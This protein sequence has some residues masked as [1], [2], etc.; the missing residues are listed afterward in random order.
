MKQTAIIHGLGEIPPAWAGDLVDLEASTDGQ[1]RVG[2][3]GVRR[4]VT[5]L[6]RRVELVAFENKTLAVVRST[7]MG[8][9]IYPLEPARFDP[10]ATAVLIDLDGTSVHSESFWMWIIER[11]IARLMGD[12]SFQLSTDD[13]PH[14]SGHSVSEHLQY[15]IN[16]YVPG[17]SIETAR[18]H[19]YEITE[20]EMAEIVAGRGKADAFTPAPGLKAF[21]LGLKAAG[22]KIG[23]VTS[24]L[25]NK[26]W[27]E[28]ISAFRQLDLG[29][30]LKFYD[31]II[32]AGQRLTRGQC[33][34]LGELAPKPHP[35]LYAEA[36]YIG[37]NIAPA[38]RQHVIGIEDSG[39]GVL[40]I[41]LAGFAAMGITGGNIDQSGTRPLLT[42]YC[43]SLPAALQFI[44]GQQHANDTKPSD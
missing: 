31:C 7:L 24:G 22:V 34:T 4:I 19:Y 35:W 3:E 36:A 8:N 44:L 11:S 42:H 5:P 12:E 20:F 37:L 23:L 18:Q 32:T 33:G 10:P 29:D 25:H 2:R 15:C 40:S 38:D 39:A 1:W 21:L 17:G 41:R 13:E 16:K 14:V 30:P 43:D 27:P 6:D 9:A 28:I 26:A